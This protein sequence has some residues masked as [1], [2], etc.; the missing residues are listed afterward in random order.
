MTELWLGIALLTMVAISFVFIPFVRAR[1]LLQNVSAEERGQQNIAI[2]RERLAELEQEQSTGNLDSVEFATLKTELERNLLTD[3][4]NKPQAEGSLQLNAQSLVTVALLAVMIPVTAIGLYSVYGRSADLEISLQQPKDP[5]NGKKPTLEEAVA[6]LEK[7]LQLS[8]ENPEGWYLLSTTYM[9][10]QR[11]AEGAAG[12]KKVL[13]LLPEDAPQYAGVMGQ[14]GQAL[15][16]AGGSKMTDEVRQQIDLTLEKEPFEITS[17]G[18]L[19]V[20]AFERQDYEQALEFWLKALRNADGNAADSLRSG[21]RKARDELLAQGKSVPEI[22]ELAEARIPVRVQLSP[23]LAADLSPDLTVFIFARDPSM[24]M[25][26]AAVKLKVSDLPADVVLDDSFA[27][28]P[29]GRLS[30]VPSVEV[31][32]RIS[33]SGQPKAQKGDLF[34]KIASVSVRGQA[35]PLILSV[36][37][38]VE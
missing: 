30:S 25:P 3:V 33:M 18:I 34:G 2:F 7:E 29:Q 20:D 8:P 1:K 27:M 17:L 37:Q 10:Q 12:F 4:D 13:E 28:T 6:Q 23:K 11:F 22:P 15:F 16:F 14:Y 38:V 35:V 32:A 21:V 9:N 31:S 5:F 19:G 26:L 24:P 36:D